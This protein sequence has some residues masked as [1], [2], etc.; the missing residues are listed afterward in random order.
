MARITLA[1]RLLC[2]FRLLAHYL[3]WIHLDA[4]VAPINGYIRQLV[5]DLE[6]GRLQSYPE[7]EKLFGPVLSL[8]PEYQIMHTPTQLCLF[9]EQGWEGFFEDIHRYSMDHFG[10]ARTSAAEAMTLA[11]EAVLPRTGRSYPHVVDL[12]HDVAAFLRDNRRRGS[13][14]KGPLSGYPP[15]SIKVEDPLD[16]SKFPPIQWLASMNSPTPS[17]E[18]PSDLRDLILTFQK[19]PH[20][21][22]EELQLRRKQMKLRRLPVISSEQA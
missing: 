10:V 9:V 22:N 15:A 5:A 18:L 12:P 6:N 16:R 1:Y 4:G 11:T 20:V 8:P 14:R 19:K 17:F 2:A 7:L 3:M 21:S 13:G